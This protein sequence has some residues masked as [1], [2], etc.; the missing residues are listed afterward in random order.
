MKITLIWMETKSMFANKNSIDG[1]MNTDAA[2]PNKIS[3]S[4]KFVPVFRFAINKD[5]EGVSIY[6]SI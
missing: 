5:N 1:R 4:K 2:N 6:V 3:D